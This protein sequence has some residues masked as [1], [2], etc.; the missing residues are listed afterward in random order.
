MKPAAAAKS[1]V[2][3]LLARSMAPLAVL[4]RGED[5]VEQL[6]LFGRGGGLHAPAD[7]LLELLYLGDH[8]LHALGGL[9]GA[10]IGRLIGQH[11]I[12]VAVDGGDALRETLD[13]K[14]RRQFDV[15]DS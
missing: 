11:Q 14:A 8:A 5:L 6:I 3:M 9:V 2:T 7:V 4:Q 10:D 15:R 1:T 13:A 12:K